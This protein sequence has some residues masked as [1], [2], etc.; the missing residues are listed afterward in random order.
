MNSPFGYLY[1]MLHKYTGTEDS[2]L[3]PSSQSLH[4]FIN[5]YLVQVIFL[6]VL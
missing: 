3:K 5:N 6:L 1:E 2:I 4:M